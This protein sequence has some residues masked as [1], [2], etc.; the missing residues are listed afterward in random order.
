MPEHPAP[1]AHLRI[2]PLGV[3]VQE[4]IDDLKQRGTTPELPTGIPLL[5]DAIWGLHRSEL[6]VIAAR[7]GEGKTSLCLQL[8][9]HLADQGRR[10]L[11]VSLEMTRHQLTERLLVQMTQTD[12]WTLRRG[13]GTTEFIAKL[14]PLKV[15]WDKFNLRFVD[16][17]GYTIEQMRHLVNQLEAHGGTPD[18]LVVD[19]IQLIA[20]ESGLQR[21]DAIAEYLRMLKE[22]AM[23]HSMAV[24]VCS[25]V[26]REASKNK[27]KKPTLGNLKGSG[28]LEEL[29]DC[30]VMCWW[31]ELGSEEKPKGLKY[32]F[33]IEKQRHGPPGQMIPVRFDPHRLTFHAVADEVAE[34][35]NNGAPVQEV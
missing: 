26:N 16:G 5:D 11:F 34:W 30:V 21:F 31:E 23:L 27:N 1:P 32:W 4:V 22:L 15:L 14:E 13:Q 8:C 29:A 10:V 19:F 12:A 25:Q 6:T 17:T 28:A 33:L 24:V 7:P 20:L 9:R 18:V 3:I 35:A 2:Q